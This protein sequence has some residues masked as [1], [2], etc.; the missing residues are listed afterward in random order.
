M[1]MFQGSMII[2]FSIIFF[3][4]SYANIV[5]ITFTSLILIELLNV[6]SQIHKYTF[7]MMLMNVCT[8]VVYFMSILLLQEY[9]D[10]GYINGVFIL[11]VTA[12]VAMTWLPIHLLG[13]AIE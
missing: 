13:F 9:F 11:K 3:N 5:T 1:S 2:M 8:A 12:I 10:L 4:D 7:P 6:Y